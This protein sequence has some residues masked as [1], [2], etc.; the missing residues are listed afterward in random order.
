MTAEVEAENVIVA[1][2]KRSWAAVRITLCDD[3]LYRYG[4]DMQYSH[5]GFCAPISGNGHGTREAAITAGTEEILQKMH[6][7]FPSDPNSVREEL[8]EITAQLQNRLRQPSLL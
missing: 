5:G 3:G 8:R 4:I 6:T 7:P 2:H 1:R